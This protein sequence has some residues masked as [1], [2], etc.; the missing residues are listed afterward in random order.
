MKPFLKTRFI[1]NNKYNTIWLALYLL[2]IS[3]FIILVC[4]GV[5]IIPGAGPLSVKYLARTL[6]SEMCMPWHFS[7]KILLLTYFIINCICFIMSYCMVFIRGEEK[8]IFFCVLSDIGISFILAFGV[9]WFKDGS[10][11]IPIKAI[12]WPIWNLFLSGIFYCINM[13]EKFVKRKH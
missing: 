10:Y 6:L 11:F 12:G 1:M 9:L 8:Q 2:S 7:V 13:P 4:L 5:D 3:L